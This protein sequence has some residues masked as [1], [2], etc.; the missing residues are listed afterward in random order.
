MALSTMGNY[1]N[2]SGDFDDNGWRTWNSV[3]F[4]YIIISY[5]PIIAACII[6]IVSDDNAGGIPFFQSIEVLILST[7]VMILLLVRII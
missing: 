3:A 7:F 1:D 5:C 6:F 4:T 2:I